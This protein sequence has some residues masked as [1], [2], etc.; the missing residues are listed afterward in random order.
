MPEFYTWTIILVNQLDAIGEKQF[1]VFGSRGGQISPLI[2]VPLYHCIGTL[3]VFEHCG[4]RS[5]VKAQLAPFFG[6]W[7][8]LIS[9]LV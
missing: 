6:Q 8:N 1:S 9:G 7:L 5:I 4:F 2:H 3:C